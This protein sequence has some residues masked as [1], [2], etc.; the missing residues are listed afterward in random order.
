MFA[1]LTC[2][3][4][5]L[6]SVTESDVPPMNTVCVPKFSNAGESVRLEPTAVSETT[7]GLVT[8]LSVMVSV[9]CLVPVAVGL[10]VML[11]VQLPGTLSTGGDKVGGH[12]LV[13]LKSEP[14]SAMLEIERVLVEKLLR[15][16]VWTGLGIPTC[17]VCGKFKLV[18]E[19][20]EQLRSGNARGG[21]GD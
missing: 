8:S 2:A 6:V 18:V 19:A 12:A 15:V 14:E 10:N 13:W 7:C 4:P 5:E 3:L 17:W 1:M 20:G 16:T 21:S 11:M 9:P